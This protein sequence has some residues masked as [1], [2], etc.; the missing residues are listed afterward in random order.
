[1]S[2][3]RWLMLRGVDGRDE[4]GHDGKTARSLPY[5]KLVKPSAYAAPAPP[6]ANCSGNA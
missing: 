2:V 3:E 5:T 4:P 6:A 1:M